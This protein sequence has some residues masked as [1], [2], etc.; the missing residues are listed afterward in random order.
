MPLAGGHCA[1]LIDNGTPGSALAVDYLADFQEANVFTVFLSSALQLCW[2][3]SC[4]AHGL[5]TDNPG[6][7]DS[8]HASLMVVGKA[9]CQQMR[10]VLTR[11]AAALS[12]LPGE[13]V[14]RRTAT[15]STACR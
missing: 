1:S 13:E 7:M 10:Q 11:V 8:R 12:S 3:A 9:R 5:A 14:R 6:H 4:A 2:E 15:S